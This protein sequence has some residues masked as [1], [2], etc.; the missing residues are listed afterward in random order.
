MVEKSRSV[1]CVCVCQL[2]KH[3]FILLQV[4]DYSC[5]SLTQPSGWVLKHCGMGGVRILIELHTGDGFF[6][7]PPF[8]ELSKSEPNQES[9]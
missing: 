6:I 8:R 9:A 3:I 1:V 4:A 2:S 5:L 7:C